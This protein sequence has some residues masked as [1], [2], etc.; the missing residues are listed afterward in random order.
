MFKEASVPVVDKNSDIIV[1]L[2]QGSEGSYNS[3]RTAAK[4]I[5]SDRGVT[6]KYSGLVEISKE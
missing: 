4:Y 1:Y 3:G 6:F 5:S 2:T